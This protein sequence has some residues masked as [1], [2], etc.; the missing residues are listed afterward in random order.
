MGEGYKLPA[1]KV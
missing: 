1:C